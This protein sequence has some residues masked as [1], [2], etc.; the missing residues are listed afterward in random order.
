MAG[1]LED[2]NTVTSATGEPRMTSMAL[3]SAASAETVFKYTPTI[4]AYALWQIQKERIAIREEY[5][6]HWRSTTAE[7][8]TGRPD[9][10]IIS[11]VAPCPPSPHGKTT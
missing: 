5:T 9:D 7:T 6:R 3:D 1:A 8:G 10:A 2:I 11:P 4:S